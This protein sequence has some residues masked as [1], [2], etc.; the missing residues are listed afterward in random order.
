M[1]LLFYHAYYHWFIILYSIFTWFGIW[2]SGFVIISF[3]NIHTWFGVFWDKIFFFFLIHRIYFF[4]SSPGHKQWNLLYSAVIFNASVDDLHK[5]K[6]FSKLTLYF[7][8][9]RHTLPWLQLFCV[10]R[11]Y[12][13][14]VM[15]KIIHNPWK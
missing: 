14:K 12:Y 11:N 4:P 8:P 13:N 6:F 1:L 7:P 10:F 3:K 5:C 2:S 15:R 9:Q